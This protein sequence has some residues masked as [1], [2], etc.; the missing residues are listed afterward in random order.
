MRRSRLLWIFLACAAIQQGTVA[1]ETPAK[2]PITFDAVYGPHATLNP[3][4]HPAPRFQ[5][6]PDGVHLLQTLRGQ[7]TKVH[8]KT[9]DT[10]PLF[11]PTQLAQGLESLSDIDEPTARKLANKSHL[12]FNPAYDAVLIPH[13]DRLYFA[14]LDGSF[15]CRLTDATGT[16]E[17]AEFGPHGES[18]AFVRDNDLYSVNLATQAEQRLTTEGSELIRNGKADWVYWEEVFNRQ[19]RTFWYSGD[20]TQIVFL[21]FNDTP[22]APFSIPNNVPETQRIHEMRYPKAGTANPLVQVG[23]ASLADAAVRWVDLSAYPPEDRLVVRAGWLPDHQTVYLYLQNRSQTWLDLLVVD[24]GSTTPRRLIRETT[25]AWV[26]NLAPPHFLTDGSFLWE[27]ERSGW[28]H[29]YHYAADGQLRRAVT[30]GPWEVSEVHFVDEPAGD[31][32][33]SAAKKSHLEDHLYRVS[34]DSGEPVQLTTADGSH[35]IR[36]S[37]NGSGYL[38]THSSFERPPATEIFDGDGRRIRELHKTDTTDLNEY[39]WSTHETVSIETG[40]GGTLD[41]SLM[42]PADFDSS[43]QYPVWIKVYGGPHYPTIRNRW[44]KTHRLFDEVLA[45]SGIVIL[46][47]DPRSASGASAQSAWTAYRRLG[48]NE[49]R[50]LEHAVDWLKSKSWVDPQR[51]GLGGHSYGGF[52]TAFALTHSQS[53]AAGIAGA[54]VTDWRNYDTIYTERYMNTPAANPA[55]YDETSVVKAAKNLH[56]RLLL[57]HGMLDDNVHLQNTTQLV[58]ALQRADKDFELMLYPR[59]KH[60]IHGAHYTRTT[61]NFIIKTMLPEQTPSPLQD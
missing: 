39:Q 16:A 19:L 6:L 36:F 5:W 61:Y 42:L 58:N 27:S 38:D 23:I 43:R 33:F 21:K 50:D 56:G 1:D 29:L 47:V 35:H 2:K 17:L 31:V 49:L 59:A 25:A 48:V 10:S 15:A 12:Q 57:L 54:P 46:R 7:Y 28:R 18:V 55:G 32:Y 44:T 37:P 22:V 60:G 34:L 41:G 8:A 14:K 26:N 9:G 20:G 24:P 40:D 53:F 45:T 3:F 30:A 13:A 11:D 51:I 4:H 52:L